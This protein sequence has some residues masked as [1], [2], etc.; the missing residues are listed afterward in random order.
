MPCSETINCEP[1]VLYLLVIW[2]HLFAPVW[3]Q[4]NVRFKIMSVSPDS[5]DPLRLTGRQKSKNSKTA[6]HTRVWNSVYRIL[7]VWRTKF[8]P[9]G[10]ISEAKERSV[11]KYN[12]QWQSALCFT[13]YVYLYLC[14]ILCVISMLIIDNKDSVCYPYGRDRPEISPRSS[15]VQTLT[16][17]VF[18]WDYRPRSPRV[19]VSEFRSCVKVE[20]EV[21]G[22]R[23]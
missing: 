15:S 2:W 13:V 6:Y 16:K 21:L 14:I 19:Y 10:H 7:L 22:S 23:P 20:V 8:R 11:I 3:S 9:D 18:G 1:V 5:G 12:S 17:S 4:T